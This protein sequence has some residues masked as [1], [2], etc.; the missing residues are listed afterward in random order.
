MYFKAGTLVLAGLAAMAAAAPLTAVAG[1]E[2]TIWDAS[3]AVRDDMKRYDSGLLS[4][5]LKEK[6]EKPGVPNIN[7][8][9]KRDASGVSKRDKTYPYSSYAL[10][11]LTS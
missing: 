6:R 11:S 3:S 2:A 5:Q 1:R 10:V 7:M 4:D 9:T 8:A